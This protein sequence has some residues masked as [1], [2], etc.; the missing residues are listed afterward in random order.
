MRS[1][2]ASSSYFDTNAKQKV[3]EVSGEEGGYSYDNIGEYKRNI[4][5]G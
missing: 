2:S 3:S 5:L 4:N 1:T